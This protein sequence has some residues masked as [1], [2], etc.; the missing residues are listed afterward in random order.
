MEGISLYAKLLFNGFLHWS[1]VLINSGFQP[2]LFIVHKW[3]CLC[4]FYTEPW[5]LAGME[6]LMLRVLHPIKMSKDLAPKFH[7][8]GM[9]WGTSRIFREPVEC[10]QLACGSFCSS[11][12][13][14]KLF[15]WAI[16]SPLHFG[17]L[18]TTAWLA[19]HEAPFVR[20]HYSR[21]FRSCLTPFGIQAALKYELPGHFPAQSGRKWL[22]FSF[23]MA[24]SL[25]TSIQVLSI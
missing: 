19:K 17:L 14:K 11:Q 20:A 7:F 25:F 12:F 15:V 24:A 22:W 4:I 23:M 18:E 13:V 9:P 2:M 10:P 16:A 21:F 6:C 8:K 5:A 3:K 1:T